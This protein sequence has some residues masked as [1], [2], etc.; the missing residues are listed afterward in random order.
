ML[1]VLNVWAAEAP[2]T[3]RVADIAVAKR[4]RG[5]VQ[6]VIDY[7]GESNKDQS[8]GR[9]DI[10][11]IGGPH[12]ASDTKL[13]LG[14]L[15]AGTYSMAR[16][17]SLTPPSDVSIYGDFSVVG[18]YE[19]GV[20]GNNFFPGDRYRLSYDAYF[21]SFPNHFWGIGYDRGA[22][23]DNRSDYERRRVE[24]TA[25]FLVRCLPNFYVGPI[26]QFNYV[27]ARDAERP[28]LWEGQPVNVASTGLG[29]ALQY[30][31][32]DNK[33]SPQSGVLLE[34]SQRL[35]PRA[36]GNR[37]RFGATVFSANTYNTVWKGGVVATM[38]HGQ[39]GYGD[40]PWTML[41]VVGGSHYL[42]GYYE[43]RYTDKSEADVTVELRQHVWKRNGVVVW[44]GLGS[45]FPSFERLRA[46]MLLPNY[47]IGY[48]WEFKKYVNVR[49]DYGFG[50]CGQSGF[51][52]SVNEAF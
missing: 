42:R 47:G 21:Y 13:G 32:R 22:N 1:S 38:I 39:L 43:G 10:S 25:S 17:D 50:K 40:V 20:K 3:V 8:D 6:K 16:G 45:V 4:N 14:L 35:Y 5:L 37:R 29:Y 46:K 12:Y 33:H 52:F 49:L 24:V 34:F 44:A 30:D 11:F 18:F 41:A 9:F 19:L 48:R 51:V 23:D 36:F 31:T 28:D 7:F 26:A 15:G 27:T 2:D